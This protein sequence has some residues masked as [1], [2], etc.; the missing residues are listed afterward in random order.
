MIDYTDFRRP[1]SARSNREYNM[2]VICNEQK[3]LFNRL[4]NGPDKLHQNAYPLVLKWRPGA[5]ET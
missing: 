1:K 5:T 3:E 2:K 4:R